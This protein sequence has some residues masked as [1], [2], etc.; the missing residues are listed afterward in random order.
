M[1]RDTENGDVFDELVIATWNTGG[2]SNGQ[3]SMPDEGVAV[4]TST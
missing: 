4:A 3:L 2:G 1:Q